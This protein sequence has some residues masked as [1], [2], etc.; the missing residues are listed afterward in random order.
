MRF[1]PAGTPL[2][3]RWVSSLA[4]LVGLVVAV[5]IV[6]HDANHS[7]PAAADAQA[8]VRAN[9]EARVLVGEDQAL[10]VASL[11]AGVSPL[12]ALTRAVAGDVRARVAGHQLTGP[13][14]GTSCRRG[15]PSRGGRVPY[16]CTAR[17]AGLSYPFYG[18]VDVAA[19]TLQWCK[20]DPVSEPGLGV[21]LD[22]RCL[23]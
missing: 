6:I 15:G 5:A 22:P 20:R 4:F 23:R 18:V 3:L 7:R 1:L 16:L 13:A 19:R 14:R 17:A 11:A 12:V 21:A 10:H 9:E 2:W 8:V